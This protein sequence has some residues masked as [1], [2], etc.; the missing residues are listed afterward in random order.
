[1]KLL[2]MN[3]NLLSL[4]LVVLFIIPPGEAGVSQTFCIKPNETTE[5]GSTSVKDCPRC[6]TL[7]YYFL[8][9]NTTINQHSN[10]TLVFMSS[11]Y[12]IPHVKYVAKITSSTV[13]VVGNG[14]VTIVVNCPLCFFFFIGES[15]E[16][17]HRKSP[18]N[19]QLWIIFVSYW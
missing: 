2:N 15:N 3:Q 5:C 18:N 17:Y 9:L 11:T 7:E 13:R 10:V 8:N 19:E 16:C 14:T 1:M 6:H 4:I 12:T